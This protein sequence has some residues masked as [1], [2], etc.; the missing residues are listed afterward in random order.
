MHSCFVLRHSLCDLINVQH[1]LIWELMFNE[2]QLGH[3]TVEANKNICCVKGEDTID[4]ITATRGFKKFSSGCKNFDDQLNQVGSK[5]VDSEAMFQAIKANQVSS[6]QK[7][8]D[9]QSSVLHHLSLDRNI[10]SC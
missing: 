7:V 8:S 1:S 4:H 5:T 3:N 10:Q 6:I 9:E 2:F